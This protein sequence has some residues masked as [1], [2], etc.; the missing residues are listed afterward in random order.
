MLE[1]EYDYLIE[2]LEE[3]ESKYKDKTVVIIGME[4]VGVHDELGEAYSEAVKKYELGTFLLETLDGTTLEPVIF[5]NYNI[6]ENGNMYH[7]L[8]DNQG[9]KD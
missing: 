7:I 2:N 5:H 1:V 4:V 9:G 6:D 8:G 3:L